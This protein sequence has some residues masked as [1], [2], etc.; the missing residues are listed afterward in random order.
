MP[1]AMVAQ[2]SR[3]EPYRVLTPLETAW[4]P[5]DKASISWPLTIGVIMVIGGLIS[6]AN[7]RG[8]EYW[9]WIIAGA[10]IAWYGYSTRPDRGAPPKDRDPAGYRAWYLEQARQVMA[11]ACTPRPPARSFESESEQRLYS[12]LER[13]HL[14]V[15]RQ[16][17]VPSG[18][19]RGYEYCADI[20]Y[21]DPSCGL[22]IDIEVDGS[23]K[24]A[25]PELQGK[26]ARRDQRFTGLGW[27]VL[28]FHA[29]DAYND[30]AA[31]VRFVQNYV[32]E[33]MLNHKRALG[34]LQVADD[35]RGGAFGSTFSK[36]ATGDRAATLEDLPF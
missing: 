20:A 16:Q 22:R 36:S 21:Y 27:H 8:G 2:N 32:D 14:S 35:L 7:S 33:A 25:N 31:C 26:M 30:A 34:M 15:H 10:L 6:S 5:T 17:M 3:A 9:L 11:Q 13:A 12:A 19:G 18:Y 24:D 4:K 28:R 29:V 1:A 23:F